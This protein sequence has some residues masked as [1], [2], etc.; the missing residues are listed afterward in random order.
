M[1]IWHLQKGINDATNSDL[2]GKR[3]SVEPRWEKLCPGFYNWFLT[4][5]RKKFL[6]CQPVCE[7]RYGCSQAV[8]PE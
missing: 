8:L 5:S 4:H 1:Y 6:Q 2:C 3:L 7:R